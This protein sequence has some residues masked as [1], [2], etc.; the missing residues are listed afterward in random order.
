VGVLLREVQ[1]AYAGRELPPLSVQYADYAAWQRIWLAGDVME[2][3]L[4]Y[5]REQ[6]AGAPP[7]L[8]LPTDRPRPATPSHQ[9][10]Q[11]TEALDPPTVTRLTEAAQQRGT[12]LF[13]VLQSVLAAVLSRRSG[14]DDVVIG[15]PVANRSRVETED[16]IGF[17]VN[18]L[19]LR[20]RVA[21]AETFEELLDRVSRTALEGLSHQDVPFDRLVQE[22]APDRDRS[23][24]PLFQ[25]ML[26]FQNAPTT[27]AAPGDLDLTYLPVGDS[28]AKFDLML[29]AEETTGGELSLVLEYSTDLFTEQTARAVLDD[30]QRACRA[31]AADPARPVGE[32][33]PVSQQESE[34]LRTWNRTDRY[35]QLN[36][37]IARVR[38]HAFTRPDAIALTDDHGSLTYAE[39]A[40]RASRLTRELLAAG[41][42]ADD[43][44]AY[45]G[46][47]GVD[48]VVAFLG[49]LGAGGA[50]LPLDPNAPLARKADMVTASG[51]RHLITTAG[52]T[53]QTDAIASEAGRPGQ[54]AQTDA[55]A[56][57]AG[58]HPIVLV[59]PTA[60]DGPDALAPVSTA[61]DDLAYVLYTSGSTGRPKGAMVHHAGMNNHLLA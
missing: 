46:E 48:A 29:L 36:S 11:L 53:A 15:V 34:L 43:R 26:A 59:C 50:Y 20:T 1:A 22:L 8:D 33:A 14:Q 23:R 42:T 38:E 31:A 19:P 51:A 32:L 45:H 25:V 52:H 61:H 6:L 44:V 58:T 17:F 60:A 10:A 16:L 47:R 39:L 54:A 28:T 2:E 3:Q 4:A 35:D 57:A 37:L 27:E 13:S 9:G 5:W 12:T 56:S 7:A 41:V 21:A 18:T 24:N 55:I 30:I 49:I 40:G